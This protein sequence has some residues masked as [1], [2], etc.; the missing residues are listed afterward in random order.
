MIFNKKY[1]NNNI[2]SE[3]ACEDSNKKRSFYFI[4]R[5]KESQFSY[6]NSRFYSFGYK[7]TVKGFVYEDPK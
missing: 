7:F 4:P 5:L 1:S 3:N 6:K 2:Y